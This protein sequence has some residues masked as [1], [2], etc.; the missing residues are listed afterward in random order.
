MLTKTCFDRCLNALLTFAEVPVDKEKNKMFYALMRNDFEDAEFSQIAGDICKTE[1]LYGRY[2]AP[3]LFYDRKCESDKE[4]FVSI[5]S[6]HLEM[7]DEAQRCMDKMSNSQYDRM[8]SWMRGHIDGKTMKKSAISKIVLGFCSE[9][10]VQ[11][12][13]IGLTEIKQLLEDHRNEL[14]AV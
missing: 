3:K 8:I 11:Q 1:S 6:G 4:V 9:K 2:P 10:P 7:S 5:D 14:E 13:Y 12:N